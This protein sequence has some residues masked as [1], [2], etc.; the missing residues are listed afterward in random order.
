MKKRSNPEE[1]YANSTQVAVSV[2]DCFRVNRVVDAAVYICTYQSH[3]NGNNINFYVS[4]W[5]I[6]TVYILLY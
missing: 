3:V 4:E 5:Y 2:S 1:N 6:Y